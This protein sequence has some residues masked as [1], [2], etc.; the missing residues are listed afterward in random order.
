MSTTSPQD[1][2]KRNKVQ[3]LKQQRPPNL[4]L[5]AS[6]ILMHMINSLVSSPLSLA[7]LQ[8]TLN[9]TLRVA[10][11]KLSATLST[12]FDPLGGLELLQ[13]PKAANTQASTSAMVLSVVILATIRLSLLRF[14]LTPKR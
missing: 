8:E 6:E 9:F 7:R 5:I 1:L 4:K 3:L 2:L 12:L 14:R 10:K 13:L 11:V